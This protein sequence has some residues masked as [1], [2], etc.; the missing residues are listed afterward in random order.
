L[1]PAGQYVALR[2]SDAQAV[3]SGS[4]RGAVRGKHQS[5]VGTD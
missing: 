1:L 3:G 2:L 4:R 5:R